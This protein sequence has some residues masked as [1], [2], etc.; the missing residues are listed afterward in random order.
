MIS[1]EEV[2]AKISIS[3]WGKISFFLGF[4]GEIVFSVALAVVR[5]VSSSSL[6]STVDW[7]FFAVGSLTSNSVNADAAST[8]WERAPIFSNDILL[9]STDGAIICQEAEL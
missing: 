3:F 1:D 2:S 7:A 5:G 4:R 8:S 9:R 6:T